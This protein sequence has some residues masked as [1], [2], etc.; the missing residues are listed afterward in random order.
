[1]K[2]DPIALRAETFILSFTKMPNHSKNEPKN[3]N[4]SGAKVAYVITN[5]AAAEGRNRTILFLKV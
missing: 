5:A 1:V 4:G 2:N 3:V